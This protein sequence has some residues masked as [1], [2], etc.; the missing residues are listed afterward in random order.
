MD[1]KSDFKQFINPVKGQIEK[2]GLT[3]VSQES[4]ISQKEAEERSKSLEEV[5]SPDAGGSLFPELHGVAWTGVRV[6]VS[7]WRRPRD[8]SHPG[9][10]DLCFPFHSTK[11]VSPSSLL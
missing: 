3:R 4:G 11:R 8:I 2:L 9:K 7:G 1:F 10:K 6:D 5:C